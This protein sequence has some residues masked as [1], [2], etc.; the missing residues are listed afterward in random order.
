M[1]FD[2]DLLDARNVREVVGEADEWSRERAGHQRYENAAREA[3]EGRNDARLLFVDA[4]RIE[5]DDMQISSKEHLIADFQNVAA[6]PS[7]TAAE[8][9][10]WK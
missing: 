10:E 3:H 4:L 5:W 2:Q 8:L 6:N 7:I 1:G 9:E